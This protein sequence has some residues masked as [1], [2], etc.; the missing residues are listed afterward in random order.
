MRVVLCT[1]GARLPRVSRDRIRTDL[2]VRART[3][4]AKCPSRC[5]GLRVV[6]REK[7]AISRDANKYIDQQF[8]IKIKL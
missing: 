2:E 5:S 6:Q 7:G 3:S 4:V 8:T 1:Q